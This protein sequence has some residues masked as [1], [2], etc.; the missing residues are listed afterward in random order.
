MIELLEK[1]KNALRISTTA[2]DSE[3]TMLIRAA[4]IDLVRVG[5]KQSKVDAPDDYI[6]TAIILY[7]KANFGFNNPD[8]DK[9][10]KAYDTV[11]A[12]LALSKTYTGA[13]LPAP[14]PG[15]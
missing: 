3:I 14:A 8:Y 9:L 1:C 4:Q 11:L 12:Q 13:A 15:V 7:V 10:A 2:C 6:T 5:V